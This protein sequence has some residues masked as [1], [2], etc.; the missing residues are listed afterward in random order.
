LKLLLLLCLLL[1][2]A[3]AGA[4]TLSQDSLKFAGYWDLIESGETTAANKL[5]LNMGDQEGDRIEKL[6][7]FF[8]AWQSIR[9]ENYENIP[10]FIELGIPPELKDHAAWMRANALAQ[11]GQSSLAAGYWSDLVKDTNSVYRASA[12]RKLA[13]VVKESGNLDSLIRI[14]NLSDSLGLITADQQSLGLLA[15]QALTAIGQHEQAVNHLWSA[16]VSNAFS[17]EGKQA[18]SLLERYQ[19]L[20][21]FKPRAE[22]PAEFVE[23]MENLLSNSHFDFGLDRVEELQRDTSWIAESG[24]LMYYQGRFQSVMRQ[25][26]NA[27]KTLQIQI[28]VYPSSRFHLKALYSLARSAYFANEDSIALKAFKELTASNADSMLMSQTYELIGLM[29]MD[30]GHPLAA[31]AAY[32]DWKRYVQGTDSEDDCLWRLGWAQWDAKDF[33]GAIQS[34]E[35]LEALDPESD[36]VPTAR[37]WIFRAAEKANLKDKALDKRMSLL[38]EFPYSYY[39]ILARDSLNQLVDS[40]ECLPWPKL[41]LDDMYNAGGIHTR[42]FALLATM[43][44]TELA[45]MEWPLALNEIGNS[46]AFK[47]WKVQCYL[48][49]GDRNTAYRTVLKYLRP[50]VIAGGHDMPSAFWSLVYP[51][52]FDPLILKYTAQDSLDPYLLMGLICQESHYDENIVSPVGAVGLMQLMPTTARKQAR[53]LKLPYSRNKLDNADYNLHIGMSH[54][55]SLMKDFHGDTILVLCAYNAGPSAA[56]AWYEE[57]GNRER[58]VFVE[59]IPYRETRLFVKRILEHAAAYRRL[60]PNLK[61][62]DTSSKSTS[63][64]K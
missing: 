46:P 20:Y 54:V 25:H 48:W 40:I 59:M 49:N 44:L 53:K 36:Y 34:W 45:L 23:E 15:A 1:C 50:Y 32:K 29:N 10:S 37:Y 7:N 47:W 63:S 13:T 21:Q 31:S 30:R 4:E 9:S 22:T 5:L 19:T 57:F 24:M 52:D 27:V 55:A 43:R 60:Y 17:A 2:S 6:A 11:A 58:D 38:R 64:P 35:E 39:S 3:I 62:E 61:T 56:Q 12:L 28:S 18:K 14:E 51:L 8:L 42:K 41:S 33:A 16:Y 26:K